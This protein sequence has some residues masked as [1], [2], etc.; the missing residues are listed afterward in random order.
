MYIW[1]RGGVGS[2]RY[3]NTFLK[4]QN[5]ILGLKK[6]MQYN[7]ILLHI[8]WDSY[9]KKADNGKCW[10]FRR[11]WWEYK[12]V[13]PWMVAH[14]APLSMQFSRHASWSRLPFPSPGDLPDPGIEPVSLASPALA[15]GFL[16][17]AL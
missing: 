13:L 10:Q 16:P 1:G 7:K 2:P 8:H 17:L 12:M 4:S 15:G 6:C 9:N 11:C 5:N 3:R 14:Q